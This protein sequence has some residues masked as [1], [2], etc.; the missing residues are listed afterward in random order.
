M[1]DED[2]PSGRLSRVRP[3]MLRLCHMQADVTE[4]LENRHAECLSIRC[5]EVVERAQVR[6]VSRDEMRNRVCI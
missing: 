5:V 1:H 3:Q 4:T 2:F 6:F